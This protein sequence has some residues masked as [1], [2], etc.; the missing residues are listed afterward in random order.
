MFTLLA[1]LHLNG[2]LSLAAKDL[3]Q[4]VYAIARWLRVVH[5]RESNKQLNSDE[6]LTLDTTT[7]GLCDALGTL[8][9]AI[10]GNQGFRSVA[11]QKWWK[12]RRPLVVREMLHYDMHVLQWMQS[13]LSGRLQALTRMPPFVESD[14]DGRPIISG[15]QVLESVTE[16][17]VAQ[18]RAGFYIWLNACLC[19]RPL[20][21]E[22][23]MLSHLQARYNGDN[24]HV[25]VNLIVASF[26]VL[27]KA[28][29]K[30]DPAQ[31]AKMIQSFLCNK[32]PLLLTMLSTFMPPGATMDGC[33]QIAFMQ[34]SMDA[35]P[36]LEV[37]SANVR[38]KLVQARF[39]FLRACALHQLMLESNIGNILGEHVQLNKIPRFTKDGLVRQCS[40]NI[41]QIDGLLDHPTMMQGNAGAVAG[42]I[43]D[44]VNSLCFNKDTMSLKTLCNVLIKHI[45]DVDIVL[46]YAQPV[47]LLQPLCVLLNDWTH[48]QDQSEFTPAYEEYASI[49]LFTLAVIHR[50]GLSEADAGVAGTENVVF[51]LERMDAANMPPS[52]LTSDQSAQ[53][54]K[55]CE[56]LFATDEQGETSGISDEIWST[57][58]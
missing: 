24:Q 44:T 40:N 21:D 29:L 38:E 53:L 54:S 37:G 43:V 19:G 47:N 8:A 23:A 1:Q 41:G 12:Q 4:A 3:H 32:V 28:Y 15:Q 27:A 48:D 56:G 36:P 55:W 20:T 13:Q 49:L 58:S 57:L 6:L 2:G 26:D 30:G 50:Y 9:L 10:L 17:P 33:I 18:T 42:C 39:G 25:A 16:L 51:K 31:R 46:Q 35:L 52:A 11:K 22:M 45:H 7:C 34:I 5:E 14:P